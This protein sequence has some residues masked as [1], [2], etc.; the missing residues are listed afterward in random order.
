MKKPLNEEGLSRVVKQMATAICEEFGLQGVNTQGS[1]CP[2][3]K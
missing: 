2:G 1:S 3:A